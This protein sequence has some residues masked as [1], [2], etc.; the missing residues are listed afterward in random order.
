MVNTSISCCFI[1]SEE[2][3]PT[4][5]GPT[6]ADFLPLGGTDIWSRVPSTFSDIGS[7][8][9]ISPITNATVFVRVEPLLATHAPN[10]VVYSLDGS[11]DSDKGGSE[12]S[13]VG[14]R[15]WEARDL[16]SSRLLPLV[17]GER[18]VAE[19]ARLTTI[20]VNIVRLCMAQLSA[21]GAVRV[22]S[23]PIF[24]HPIACARE[25]GS[26]EI[27][28]VPGYVGLPRLLSLATDASLRDACF[29]SVV[30]FYLSFLFNCTMIFNTLFAY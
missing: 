13:V 22:V 29:A 9:A 6:T 11:V 28:C 10:R 27:F 24:V 30:C 23:A 1:P 18:S 19:L 15:F 2:E 14:S 3:L 21:L 12:G 26:G 17:N 8:T 25:T 7:P 5:L 16:A 20:D 4:L